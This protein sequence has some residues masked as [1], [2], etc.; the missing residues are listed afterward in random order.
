MGLFSN[1]SNAQYSEGGNYLKDGVFRLEIKKTILKKTR[2]GPMG[3]IV[4]CGILESTNPAHIVG[5]EATWMVTDDKEP[6]LGNVKQFIATA[7]EVEMAEINEE[8]AELIVGDEQPLKGKIVR[9][10][11][12]N[13][14]TRKNTN[15][16]KIKFIKD[17]AGAAGAAQAHADNK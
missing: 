14:L 5:S 16:T 10:S 6:F 11:G 13:I 1:I 8:V 4:E 9:A 7:L 12:I 15:F 3:F 17:S 2:K